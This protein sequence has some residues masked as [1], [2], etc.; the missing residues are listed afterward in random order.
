MV[1]FRILSGENA[2]QTKS[3]RNFPSVIGRSSSAD[4]RV[5][6]SGVWD[7]HI[8]LTM[9]ASVGFSVAAFPDASVYINGNGVSRADLRLG[10]LIEIG[11]CKMEFFLEQPRSKSLV[12]QESL[13]WALFAAL[14][15]IQCGLIFWLLR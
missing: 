5:E 9:E 12:L 4:F 15:V 2:G 3:L 8:E 10:D 14:L 1:Q 7:R 6:E 11:S 13:T